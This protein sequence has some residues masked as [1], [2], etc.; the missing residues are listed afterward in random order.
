MRTLDL[1]CCMNRWHWRVCLKGMFDLQQVLAL[2]L[3]GRTVRSVLE[4]GCHLL[5]HIVTS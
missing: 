1:C 4:S 5:G 3:F 2:C